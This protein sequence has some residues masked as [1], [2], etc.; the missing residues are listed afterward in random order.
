MKSYIL[1]TKAI[2]TIVVRAPKESRGLKQVV[3]LHLEHVYLLSCR[4][5]AVAPAPRRYGGQE[6]QR[7]EAGVRVL[8]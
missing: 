2:S 6:A 1:S 7:I 5:V 8:G 4:G 3:D